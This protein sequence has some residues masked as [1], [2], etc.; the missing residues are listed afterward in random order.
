MQFYSDLAEKSV[1]D[2]KAVWKNVTLFLLDKIM[3]KEKN[4]INCFK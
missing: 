3:S 2:N 4:N 1:T